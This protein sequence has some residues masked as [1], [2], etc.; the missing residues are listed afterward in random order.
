MAVP[1][2]GLLQGGGVIHVCPTSECHV[3]S[4]H[5]ID[6]LVHVDGFGRLLTDNVDRAALFEATA[7]FALR[8]T[9][10]TDVVSYSWTLQ[11]SQWAFLPVCAQ[12]TSQQAAFEFIDGVYDFASLPAGSMVVDFANK[13]VGGGCFARGFVQEEQMVV[14]S[15][16]FAARL[17]FHR[18]TLRSGEVISFSGVHFDAWWGGDVASRRERISPYA[19]LARPS[20]PLTVLAADAPHVRASC[21]SQNDVQ[22]LASKILLL[23]FAGRTLQCPVLCSGLLGGGAYRGNRPL[24]LLLHRLVHSAL[25][26]PFRFHLTIL[27]SFSHC[28]P[29][30]LQARTRSIAEAMLQ[31]L[32]STGVSTLRQAIAAVSTWSVPCSHNDEDL[33]DAACRRWGVCSSPGLPAPSW[34]NQTPPRSDPLPS[35]GPAPE[36]LRCFCAGC[37]CPPTWAA[38]GA[39]LASG[40]RSVMFCA[41]HLLSAISQDAIFT[42]IRL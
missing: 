16:D 8:T 22:L 21:C 17:L 18:P 13:H 1:S 12:H 39:D 4:R 11:D 38:R 9:K 26:I 5:D 27:R 19:S 42:A 25:P 29:S 20:P 24:I 15:A 30:A 41:E 31:C 14:Q 35:S 37:S 33:S 23:F 34:P 3:L 40:D 28:S 36:P 7:S 32:H 10:H 2:N 6:A